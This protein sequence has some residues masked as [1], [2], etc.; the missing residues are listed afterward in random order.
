MSLNGLEEAKV[1][2]AHTAALAEPGGW[3]LLTYVSRDEVE[4]LG[5]GNGGIFEIRNAIAEHEDPSPL[6]GFLRY[7]RRSVLIK[8]V[9]EESSRLIQARVS[10]HFTAFT[11]RFT[12]H[13]TVFAINSSKE[14]RDNSLSAA[15]SL[16]TA[17]GSDSSSTDSLQR[18]RLMEIKEEEAEEDYKEKRKSTVDEN[19]P[20]AGQE[21]INKTQLGSDHVFTTSVNKETNADTNCKIPTLPPSFEKTPPSPTAPRPLSSQ[22]VRPE[23]YSSSSYGTR[24]SKTKLGPRPS[25]DHRS[26]SDSAYRPVASLPAGLKLFRKGSKKAR[27]QSTFYSSTGPLPITDENSSTSDMRDSIR[28]HTGGGERPATSSGVSLRKKSVSAESTKSTAFTMT[29]ERAR[30]MKA[31]QLRKKQMDSQNPE[32]PTQTPETV[33]ESPKP[34]I[35]TTE[36]NGHAGAE[37]RNY[38]TSHEGEIRRSMITSAEYTSNDLCSELTKTDSSPASPV[39]TEHAASTKA[40]SLSESTEEVVQEPLPPKECFSPEDDAPEVGNVGEHGDTDVP[41]LSDVDEAQEDDAETFQANGELSDRQDRHEIAQKFSE[42]LVS[43]TA[44]APETS[45][46]PIPTPLVEE[47][48]KEERTLLAVVHKVEGPSLLSPGHVRQ[49][50]IE[51]QN[52]DASDSPTPTH[53]TTPRELKIPRSKFSMSNL[54]EAEDAA[55]DG[56][57][58]STAEKPPP[59]PNGS[60]V[61]NDKDLN[62]PKHERKTSKTRSSTSAANSENEYLEDDDDLMDELQSATIQEANPISVAKSPISQ[63]FPSSPKK[64]SDETKPIPRISS[65]PM[66]R[67]EARRQSSVRPDRAQTAR[68]VSAGDAFLSRISQQ[69]SAPTAKKVS[70]GSGIAQRMKALE[71]LAT[72][73]P[74]SGTASGSSPAF[75]SV[76]QSSIRST[77]APSIAERANSITRNN[78]SSSRSPSYSPEASDDMAKMRDRQGSVVARKEALNTATSSLFQSTNCSRPA[79]RAGSRPDSRPGQESISVTARIIRDPN[80]PFLQLPSEA[81]SPLELRSSP[82]IIDHQ[83]AEHAPT[84]PIIERRASKDMIKEGRRSSMTVVRDLFSSA[85]RA[86]ISSSDQRTIERPEPSPRPETS[87]LSRPASA[88]SRRSSYGNGLSPTLSSSPQ[89]PLSAANSKSDGRAKKMLKRMSASF[90]RGSSKTPT[91][92][93]G[94][95]LREE[96]EPTACPGSTQQLAPPPM[97][98]TDIGDVNVQFPDSLLWKRR[99]LLL[100][101]QGFLVL[102][103]SQVG[104]ASKL[105]TGTKKYHMSELKMPY[106]PDIESQELPNSVSLGFMNGGELQFACE[107]RSAQS[108]V[109]HVLE[110]AHRAFAN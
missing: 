45:L 94:P 22:S 48:A 57:P 90:S 12:P 27:T 59:I 16:H 93:I 101:A 8:Y 52:D 58:V 100:D 13:D 26:L 53:S 75:F 23:Q 91:N 79:S 78:T 10:V 15:C 85:R 35:F 39:E 6:L 68:A 19:Q 109:L 33:V 40:S 63:I 102:S 62:V 81:D 4:L 87:A 49:S 98:P 29:P 73:S 106:V 42:E 65:N 60:S 67:D 31:L 14:L 99:H 5:R 44:E 46:P 92:G 82:L 30:L 88:C 70:V 84:S 51:I 107:D 17:S 38:G 32:P 110:D 47:I 2:E 37:G 104:A 25:L 69:Q 80:Q 95:T 11:E 76:R 83:K 3:F 77:R 41:S 64:R 105:V 108:H 61:L 1:V 28:P 43:K 74:A 56:A 7:R 86:S 50:G 18:R 24:K 9:P 54:R 55:N 89:P 34:E 36:G 21:S 103:A 96:T 71:K 66:L 72:S 20:L 97:M